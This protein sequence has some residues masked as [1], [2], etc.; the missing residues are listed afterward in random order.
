[1]FTAARASE[2]FVL[3]NVECGCAHTPACVFLYF[4]IIEL[5]LRV[6]EFWEAFAIF[7]GMYF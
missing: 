2:C 1:M 5:Y 4:L 7:D 3:F 6:G